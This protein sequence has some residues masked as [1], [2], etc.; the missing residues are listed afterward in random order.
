MSMV[1]K[2]TIK[3]GIFTTPTKNPFIP[4]QNAAKKTANKRVRKMLSVILK[5][6]TE[7]PLTKA[8]IDPT[9]RSISPVR[10]IIPIPREIIP[11]TA[12]CLRIFIDALI[13]KPLLVNA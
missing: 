2:V 9:E 13:V 6:I 7:N 12:E 1:A 3:A 10:Q 4:P 8:S 5:T 11:I